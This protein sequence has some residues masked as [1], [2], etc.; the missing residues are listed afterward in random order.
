MKNPKHTGS[1]LRT[2]TE[3]LGCM[4]AQLSSKSGNSV[5]RFIFLMKENEHK[6]GCKT[7][8]S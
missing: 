5:S 3:K 8:K 4:K 7:V 2:K 6:I 1:V